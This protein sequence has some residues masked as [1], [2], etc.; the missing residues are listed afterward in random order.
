M[1]VKKKFLPGKKTILLLIIFL[2]ALFIRIEYM[3]HTIIDSPIR[4]DALEYVLYGYNIVHHRTF[5]IQ[6]DSENPL[7]DSKRTPGYPLFIA[8]AFLVDEQNFFKIILY[9]QAV[10]SALMA[11]LTFYLGNRFLQLRWATAGAVLVA[12]SPHLVSMTGYVLSETLFGFVLLIGVTFF[13]QAIKRKSLL[14]FVASALFF[15]YSYIT[16]PT[17][18]F[19]PIFLAAIVFLFRGFVAN[20]KAKN[21]VLKQIIIFLIVYSIFPVGWGIRNKVNVPSDALKG[22][23]RLKIALAYGAYPGYF[24]KNPLNKYYPYRDDPQWEEFSSSIKGFSKIFRE[25]FIERPLRFIVWYLFEKPYILWS[26][27][28]LQGQGGVYVYPVITS[29]YQKSDTSLQESAQKEV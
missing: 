27:N 2:T 8:L 19:I 12:F 16:T 26:W 1:T 29:L 7:P 11:V 25:R 3:S 24:Y 17:I 6:Q 15:G 9:I 22:S 5:S 10:M 18:L 4:A 23:V 21:R 20:T 28:I 14:L 13:Y